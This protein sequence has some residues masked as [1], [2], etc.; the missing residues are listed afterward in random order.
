MLQAFN[1]VA[2]GVEG[3]DV[4]HKSLIEGA[5]K[6]MIPRLDMK[7]IIEGSQGQSSKGGYGTVFLNCVWRGTESVVVKFFRQVGNKRFELCLHEM[8]MQALA[9]ECCGATLSLLGF[10]IKLGGS[11]TQG[12]PFLVIAQRGTTTLWNHLKEVT[13]CEEEK[14]HLA[15]QILKAVSD[16]HVHDIVHSDLK[17]NTI[18]VVPSLTGGKVVVKLIDFGLTCRVECTPVKYANRSVKD[19]ERS[20]RKCFWLAPEFINPGTRCSKSTDVYALGFVLVEVLT[21]HLPGKAKGWDS[22][23]CFRAEGLHNQGVGIEVNKC[24]GDFYER[25]TVNSLLKTFLDNV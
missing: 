13:P 15:I 14:L 2:S 9:N 11:Q 21:A 19:K 3:S 20:L 24:F 25:P 1:R 7:D 23:K 10:G 18:I 12:Y 17:G 16:L 5:E 8:L 6:C 4:D 22:V